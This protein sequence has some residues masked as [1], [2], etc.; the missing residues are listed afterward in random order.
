MS[1]K[2]FRDLMMAIIKLENI[3]KSVL[4]AGKN[5]VIM[6]HLSLQV[7][8]NEY[9]AITGP[10][11]SGKTTLVN[12]VSGIDKPSTGKIIIGDYE[13]S[14]MGE[15]Q[16]VLFRKENISMIFQDFALF[17]GLTVSE[18]IQ[19]G[20]PDQVPSESDV[21]EMVSHVGLEHRKDT[22]VHYL[23]GGEKQRVAIARAMIKKPKILLADEPTAQ[24]DRTTS[25]SIIDLLFS[26]RQERPFTML[27]IT[28]DL[29]I[30]EQCDRVVDME[31][32]S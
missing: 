11:G 12:L 2:R 32:F 9:V 31:S 21:A 4:S 15:E 30:A 24:L 28:H 3:S 10:S 16:R 29:K 6:N 22:I 23:S 27:L 25:K 5:I 26:W 13:L 19:M 18:N 7:T 1:G 20:T 14:S 8:K 17:P